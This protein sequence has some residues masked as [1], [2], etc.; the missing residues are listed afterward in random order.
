MFAATFDTFK[1]RVESKNPN[2]EVKKLCTVYTN[3]EDYAAYIA[4]FLDDEA[5]DKLHVTYEELMPTVA[6][7]YIIREK[8]KVAT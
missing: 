8:E 1:R 5:N 4:V 2:L 7:F 3:S 6:T